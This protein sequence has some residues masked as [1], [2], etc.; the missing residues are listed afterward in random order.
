MTDI[1]ARQSLRRTPLFSA[2]AAL[3]ARMVAFAGYAM[4]VQYPSGILAEHGWTRAHASLFDISHM[5]QAR[6]VADDRK[7]ETA[8]AALER[9]VPGDLVGMR[10]GRQRYTQL[11]NEE[12]GTIDDLMV[13]RLHHAAEDGSLL[14]VVNASRKEIDY[15]VIADALPAGVRIEPEPGRALLAIQG[16][17]A[18]KALASLFPPAATLDFMHAT[19]ARIGTFDCHVTRSG[20][21]GED[22]FEIS[23]A[24]ENAPRLWEMLLSASEVRPAG[25]GAR[26][27]LRLEAGLCLYGHELDETTSPVEAGLAWSIPKRRRVEGGFPGAKRIQDELAN[28]PSRL[29]VGLH[30][31]GRALAREGSEILSVEA[32]RIGVVTSGGFSPTLEKPIAMGYVP[33]SHARPDTPVTLLVRGQELPAR[34]TKLPFVAHKYRRAS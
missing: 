9:L 21:T 15:Q 10:P 28:G 18:A 27:S 3:G 8:A 12:G 19:S 2:H 17:K 14:L 31:E 7:Q 4:P 16:P 24:E 20:Y 26:D 5:G 30:L 34:I 29:C 1:G 13:T 25:L 6:V 32:E 22:G 11:L 23:V 33:A